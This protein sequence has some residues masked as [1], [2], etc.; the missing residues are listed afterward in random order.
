VRCFLGVEIEDTT[1]HF[2][3]KSTVPHFF[4]EINI[5]GRSGDLNFPKIDLETYFKTAKKQEVTTES[6]YLD[7]F[8]KNNLFLG[9]T[10]QSISEVFSDG[11]DNIL[12]GIDNAKLPPVLGMGIYDR[13]I[14]LID[15]AFQAL[16]IAAFKHGFAMIPVKVS[17]I[18]F[19]PNVKFSNYMYAKPSNLKFSDA[20][21]SG[22]VLLLNEKGD[23]VIKLSGIVL[24][25]I[26]EIEQGKS[27]NKKI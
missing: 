21:F 17:E 23:V 18:V 1:C 15:G 2:S 4:G 8:E 9:P 22:D 24:K 13:L 19:I 5:N 12:I 25:R 16:G 6:I 7:F 11:G 26:N 27:K 14:Q 20:D 3:I 10:F